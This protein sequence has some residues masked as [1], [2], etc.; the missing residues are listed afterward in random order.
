MFNFILIFLNKTYFFLFLF[1][2]IKIKLAAFSQK[3]ERLG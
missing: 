2:A 1:S 3:H